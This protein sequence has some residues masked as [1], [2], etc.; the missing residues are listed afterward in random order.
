MGAVIGGI[1]PEAVGIAISPIPVIAAIL[2]LL[3]RRARS[4]SVGFLVGWLVGVFVATL[5]FA[6]AAAA[7]STTAPSSGRPVLGVVQVLLGL[8]LLFLAFR[9]W[10]KRPRDGE[11]AALPAWLTA[12]D[13]LSFGTALGLGILLS[14]VNPKNL[15]LAASAGA[16]VGAT[17]LSVGATVGA[18]GI[19]TLVASLT[20]LVPVI[21]YLVAAKRLE[22]PLRS[23]HDW[24]VRENA[25]IMAIL[26]LV[27]GAVVLGK[28]L[29]A[30][31]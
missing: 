19:F 10:R 31:L 27:L 8:L 21:G 1:L 23:L 18:I 3:S 16:M 13:R 22:R 20:I 17:D 15:V 25:A 5:V 29:T 14:A 30:L 12:I 2:M 11:E 9:Q 24:L 4:T 26:F 6:I 28:G 7:V